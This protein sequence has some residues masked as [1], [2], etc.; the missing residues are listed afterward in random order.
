MDYEGPETSYVVPAGGV[1]APG[2]EVCARGDW[3]LG[4]LPAI[5]TTYATA[6]ALLA[7]SCVRRNRA[8]CALFSQAAR[9]CGWWWT[10]MCS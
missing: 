6:A 4:E 8:C 7:A 1:E 2:I 10:Q 3:Q 9:A 5:P